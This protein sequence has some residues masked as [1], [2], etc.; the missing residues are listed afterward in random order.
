MVLN[1]KP[2]HCSRGL[3]VENTATTGGKDKGILLKTGISGQNF[4]VT[5][6]KF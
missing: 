2:Q 3:L 1:K 6:C 4:Y 5:T